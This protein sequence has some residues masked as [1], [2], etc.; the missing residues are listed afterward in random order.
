MGKRKH[1]E[2]EDFLSF[3]IKERSVIYYVSFYTSLEIFLESRHCPVASECRSLISKADT[4]QT[5]VIL[6]KFEC[7]IEVDIPSCYCCYKCIKAHADTGCIDCNEFLCTFFPIRPRTRVGKSVS[8]ELKEALFELLREM[9]L[10]SITVEGKLRLDCKSFVNDVVQTVDELKGPV[11]I[12]RFWHVPLDLAT[13]VFSIVTEVVFGAE[14][15]CSEAFE[16]KENDSVHSSS[17]ESSEDNSDSA[18]QEE[19]ESSESD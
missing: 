1:K 10:S 12:I 4:C 9:K 2:K 6:D 17:E 15:E 18:D 14:N 16:S 11:D 5:K 13:N 19:S 7:N 3:Y 8:R